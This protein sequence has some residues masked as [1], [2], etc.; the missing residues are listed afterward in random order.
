M[1]DRD[2][3]VDPEDL[4]TIDSIDGGEPLPVA[5]ELEPLANIVAWYARVKERPSFRETMPGA[6]M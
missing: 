6:P 1:S 3:P 5:D 2:P 4:P